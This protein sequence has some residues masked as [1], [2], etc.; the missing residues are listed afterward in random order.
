VLSPLQKESSKILHDAFK[1]YPQPECQFSDLLLADYEH[2]NNHYC[3]LHLPIE[4][5]QKQDINLNEVIEHCLERKHTNFNYIVA[6]G[7]NLVFKLNRKKDYSFAG[8]QLTGVRLTGGVAKEIYMH[9]CRLASFDVYKLKAS[10]LDIR[11]SCILSKFDIVNSELERLFLQS[12]TIE[13]IED[14]HAFRDNN[15]RFLIAGG[16]IDWVR[17]MN[18][19]LHV[20]LKIVRVEINEL[21]FSENKFYSC[22]IIENRIVANL[23]NIDMPEKSSFKFDYYPKDNPYILNEKSTPKQFKTR[24]FDDWWQQ[25]KRFRD[26]YKIAKNHDYYIEQSDYFSLMQYCLNQT[27]KRPL[28]LKVISG[29]YKIFSDYGQS[30]ARP[31]FAL[32][33]AT[34]L[35]FPLIYWIIGVPISGSLYLSLTN[36][37]KP[38]SI[39]SI[40]NKQIGDW[41]IIILG[42][43]ESIISIALL[44]CF[45]L[46]LRWN[47]RKA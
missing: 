2:E 37:F 16:N 35:L 43:S 3:A 47:F 34:L 33:F 28:S 38:F 15:F 25:A 12:N 45:I 27:Q 14:W 24:V 23:S 7:D 9:F 31:V 44:A 1:N 22:P 4:A 36:A 30:V 26:L 13:S 42:V 19:N 29:L 8:A 18:N 6:V 20:T 40:D 41:L 21:S 39:L 11:D 46:A 5:S 17:L 10:G 32:I